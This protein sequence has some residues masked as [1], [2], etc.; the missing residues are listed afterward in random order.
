MMMMMMMR[1]T[2]PVRKGGFD[3]QLPS[4]PPGC[5]G[6]PDNRNGDQDENNGNCDDKDDVGDDRTKLNANTAAYLE[7]VAVFFFS[8]DIFIQHPL[9][10]F[11]YANMQN[12]KYS[13][14]DHGEEEGDMDPHDVIC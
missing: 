1:R 4:S 7:F 8:R 11:K 9:Q 12:Y 6:R 5:Q 14:Y 10:I 3:P 13:K 2:I